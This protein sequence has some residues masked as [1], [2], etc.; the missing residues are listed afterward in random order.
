MNAR[1]I[2]YIESH[3]PIALEALPSPS[4]MERYRA[5]V[6]CERSRHIAAAFAGLG[7]KL[8]KAAQGFRKITVTPNAGRLHHKTA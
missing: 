2:E 5:N 7:R 8:M 6:K 3:L 4:E 1:E